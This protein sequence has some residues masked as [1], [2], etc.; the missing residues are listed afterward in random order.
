MAPNVSRKAKRKS[1]REEKKRSHHLK[2]QR[3]P[4]GPVAVAVAAAAAAPGRAR[5][6]RKRPSQ[7]KARA[8]QNKFHELLQ[9]TVGHS[10]ALLQSAHS[11]RAA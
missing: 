2:R 8:I 11:G 5:D 6:S 4:D 7:P 3:R 10:G 9:E 1:E